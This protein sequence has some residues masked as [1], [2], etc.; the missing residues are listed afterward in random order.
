MLFS[1]LCYP[2]L[3]GI[4]ASAG[5]PGIEGNLYEYEKK[6]VRQNGDV[7][8]RIDLACS[9]ACGYGHTPAGAFS[10]PYV[11]GNGVSGAQ[12]IGGI[13]GVFPQCGF[14]A[15]AS[16]F[17]AGGVI[18]VGTLMAVFLSTSDEMLPIFI[19]ESVELPV[20]LK[21]LGVKILIGAV[22]GFVLDI[23]WRAGSRKR[24]EYHEHRHI[25]KEHHEKD[26]H[27]L[28]EH[29]HCHCEEGSILKSAVIHSLQITL[30]IFLV[31]LVIGF[32]VE[33]LGED[34]IG[35]I[36]GSQPVLGVLLAGLV[37]MIPNCAG[38]VI[39]TQMYLGRILGTGQMLAGLL[40]GAGVGILVLCRTNRGAKEN[41]GIIGLLYGISVCW[42][43]LFEVL[44][45]Q[46]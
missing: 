37:G 19:S 35:A 27:D 21:I 20:I 18:S 26:I 15:A 9:Y 34:Q 23:L 11:S 13:A 42:G 44:Q 28:C 43:I 46:F 31:T 36:I 2:L 3:S 16:S 1:N 17:Y 45:I 7:Y 24:K 6:P 30:F 12:N 33:V 10:L 14:S 5:V 29:E 8:D 41:L 38:S 25:H 40:A 39:I 32:L 4:P 22:S